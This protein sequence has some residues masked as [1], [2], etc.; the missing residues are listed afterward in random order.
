MFDKDTIKAIQESTS[1]AQAAISLIGNN[2]SHHLA[3]LPS[4]FKL[5]DIEPFLENRRRLRGTMETANTGSFAD[6]AQAN[7]EEGATVFIDQNAMSA[8][9]VLNLGTPTSPGHADNK[10]VLKPEK[11]AAYKALLLHANGAGNSQKTIAEF[12]EDWAD[13]CAC[14]GADANPI[15]TAQAVAAVRK[16][17]IDSMR[18]IESEEQSLGASKSAFE[19]VQASSKEPLPVLIVFTCQPYA[20]LGAREFALR[21][22]VLTG[23]AT[24]KV[25][26]RIS[27]MEAHQEQMAG[28]LFERIEAQ[29]GGEI[30]IRI[31]TY[32]RAQ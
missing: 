28:E 32:Q 5:H 23:E 18:K 29:F 7:A 11:T 15:K 4:D 13:N 30:A 19:S 8:T 31:G 12:L 26:L 1:I 17:T 6:Y 27:K 2:A 22:G 16:I 3:A 21:L 20:D 14:F 25:N 10:A 24:P 9:A